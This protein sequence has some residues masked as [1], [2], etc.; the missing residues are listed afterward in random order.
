MTDVTSATPPTLHPLLADRW[1]PRAYDIAHELDEAALHSVLEA[2]RWAPSAVNRQ[3]WRFLVGRRGDATFKGVYDALMPGNQLWAG[4]ASAL[5]VGLA[6]TVDAE[7]APLR[8]APYELGLSVAQLTL[9]A[10]ALGLHVHQMAGF[11]DEALLAQFDVPAG[12]EAFIVLAIGRM[13]DPEGL[14]EALRAR[15]LAPR[16][17]MP[18]P[19][20]AFSGSWGTPAVG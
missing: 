20:I 13:G 14:P 18:L 12:Y 19:Q 5:V 16:E 4:S 9:Q 15:E 7:G 8:H 1:S 2:A 10:H 6:A 17:R 3:P 11:S